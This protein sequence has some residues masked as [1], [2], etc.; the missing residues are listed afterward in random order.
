MISL[1]PHAITLL[2]NAGVMSIRLDLVLLALRGLPS[3]SIGLDGLLRFFPLPRGELVMLSSGV[4][5]DGR[6]DSFS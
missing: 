3:V 6:E 2:I 5:L 4:A 1:D